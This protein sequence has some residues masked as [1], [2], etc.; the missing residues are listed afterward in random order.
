MRAR[1]LVMSISDGRYERQ[2]AGDPIFGIR[3]TPSVDPML[4]CQTSQ[5]SGH[6]IGHELTSGISRVEPLN[7]YTSEAKSRPAGSE[8]NM[9]IRQIKRRRLLNKIN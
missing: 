7:L 9:P 1:C 8:N 4:G 3:P 6:G 5:I 2:G